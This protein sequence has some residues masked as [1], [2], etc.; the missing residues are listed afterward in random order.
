MMGCFK[1]RDVDRVADVT[2]VEGAG[3]PRHGGGGEGGELVDVPVLESDVRG[4][5]FAAGTRVLVPIAAVSHPVE[6]FPGKHRK[7]TH[8]NLQTSASTFVQDLT[9]RRRM[10]FQQTLFRELIPQQSRN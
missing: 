5:L 8:V 9:P 2:E 6:C 3:G 4:G 10:K 1:P 7:F